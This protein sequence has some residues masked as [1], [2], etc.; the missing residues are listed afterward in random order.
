[1]LFFLVSARIP[2][3][4]LILG[5]EYYLLPKTFVD[6]V[7]NYM[8][9]HLNLEHKDAKAKL[10]SYC[11]DARKLRKKALMVGTE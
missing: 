6:T 1:M 11:N 9:N 10:R 4:L 3:D 8:V 2:E 5:E 7:V